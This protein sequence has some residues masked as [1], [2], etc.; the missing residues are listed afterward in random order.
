MGLWHN[1][2]MGQGIT[3]RIFSA[4]KQVTEGDK[5]DDILLLLSIC[6]HLTTLT[7]TQPIST[8]H[9]SQIREWLLEPRK[10]NSFLRNRWIYNKAF[11][12]LH[13]LCRL[14]KCTLPLNVFIQILMND[15]INWMSRWVATDVAVLTW[16]GMKKHSK[17]RC[18]VLE[19]VKDQ[20][21]ATV[22]A[23]W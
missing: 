19:T 1:G 11:V 10:V 20:F 3:Q 21:W 22:V 13:W 2:V 16:N 5:K 18:F 9:Y 4:L 8:L 17:E 15:I 12:P 23:Q 6:S 14:P 7:E